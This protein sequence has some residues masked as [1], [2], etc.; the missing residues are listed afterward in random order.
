MQ[1]RRAYLDAAGPTVERT[2]HL[3]GAKAQYS[4]ATDPSEPSPVGKTR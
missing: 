1:Q 4:V 3:K 2:A